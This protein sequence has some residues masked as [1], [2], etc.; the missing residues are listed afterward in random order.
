MRKESFETRASVIRITRRT[1]IA[2]ALLGKI[3]FRI[4]RDAHLRSPTFDIYFALAGEKK[5]CNLF[6]DAVYIRLIPIARAYLLVLKNLFPLSVRRTQTRDADE[7]SLFRDR[8][9]LEIG[10]PR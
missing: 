10:A 4:R 5:K 3:K 6:N 8:R 9:G 1:N 2:Q 7:R